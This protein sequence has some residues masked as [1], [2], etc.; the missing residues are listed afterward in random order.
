MVTTAVRSQQLSTSL[1]LSFWIVFLSG[2]DYYEPGFVSANLCFMVYLFLRMKMQTILGLMSIVCYRFCTILRL[3]HPFCHLEEDTKPIKKQSRKDRRR[4][5]LQLRKQQKRYFKKVIR[6]G[7]YWRELSKTVY[8]M[9]G[10]KYSVLCNISLIRSVIALHY[11]SC[12][13][14]SSA[15]CVDMST[16]LLEYWIRHVS[17]YTNGN[18]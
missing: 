18:K 2:H 13:W 4:C 9:Y 1:A 6:L 5:K 12:F 3:L 11:L 7:R 8:E 10:L 14:L 17:S 15:L 16:L